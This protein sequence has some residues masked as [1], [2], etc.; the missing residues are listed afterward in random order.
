M[1]VK[2]WDISVGWYHSSKEVDL[3]AFFPRLRFHYKSGLL[4]KK[5]TIVVRKWF[6]GIFLTA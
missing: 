5:F 4:Y 3:L 6:A 2:L 1:Q